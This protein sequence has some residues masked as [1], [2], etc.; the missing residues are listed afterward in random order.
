MKKGRKKNEKGKQKKI[1][2]RGRKMKK[3]SKKNEKGKQ[4][5]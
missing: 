1:N 5:K 3:E 2:R 4:E